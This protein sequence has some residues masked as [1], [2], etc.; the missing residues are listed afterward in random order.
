MATELI[1]FQKVKYHK[2]FLVLVLNSFLPLLMAPL[3]SLWMA[4]RM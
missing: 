4:L 2:N 1:D 3:W